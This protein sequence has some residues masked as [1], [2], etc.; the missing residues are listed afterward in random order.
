MAD[1]PYIPEYKNLNL[2]ILINGL[3]NGLNNLLKKI[4]VHYELNKIPSAKLHF[5]S[6]NPQVETEENLLQSDPLKV[7]D[8][9]EINVNTGRESHRLFK[10]LIY[11][12]ERNAEPSDGFETKIECKDIAIKLTSQLEQG[13][14]ETFG[15]KMERYLNSIGM[16]NTVETGIWSDE[17]V[18]K[19]EQ[20]TPWDYLLSYLDSL[21]LM[22]TIRD[23]VF[24][25]VNI[26]EK[27]EN[28][29]YLA[30]NGINIFEFEA[31]S[32]D[33][34]ADV[35]IRYWNPKTQ[36]VEKIESNTEISDG[37]GRE[38]IDMSQS[39]YTQEI[40]AI[41]TEARAA[42]NRLLTDK[43]I[44]KTFGN[45]TANYGTY[46]EFNK[47]NPNIDSKP[48]LIRSEN[49]IIENGCWFTEYAFG[50]EDN[51]S[52]A[53]KISTNTPNYN[54]I[55]GE[56]NSMKGLQIGIVTQIEGDPANEFRVRVR[57]TSISDSAEGVWARLSSFQAGSDR[58]SF[59]VPEVDDEVIVGCINNNPD[60]PVILGKLY[61]SSRPAPFSIEA[62]NNIQG[63]VT[64]KNT[65]F[66]INDD[67]MSVEI[68]TDKGN[69]LLISDAEKG[70][71]LEDE[72][73]NKLMMNSEGITLESVK[74]I[75][76]KANANINTESTNCTLKS[77]AILE[78]SGQL[79]KLN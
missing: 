29:S 67:E 52:F 61:S 60:T 39:H 16:S 68:S 59:F 55:T 14:D 27:L 4:Q 8:E 51:Q 3:N 38:V 45:A 65:K 72:N 24:S 69:K 25:V 32:E 35:E 30:Q 21:G 41:I 33:S 58:G 34:V 43:G 31:K 10:G 13:T 18:S 56:T 62:E 79:I 1:S 54:I 75:T 7:T 73:G 78:L 44:V 26:T 66:I 76:L 70:F 53:Q 12:I 20:T 22:T 48:L 46:I 77:N 9:I 19:T 74:D 28:T 2:E 50:L 49:H 57:L 47:V 64:K 17:V 5:I 23:G 11:K 71:V 36:S 6:S 37:A 63:I 15:D 40:L 42:K